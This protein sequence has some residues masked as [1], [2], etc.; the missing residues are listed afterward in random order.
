MNAVIK[1]S[2]NAVEAYWPTLFCKAMEGQDIN[3]LLTN[4]GSAAPAGAVAVSGD[5]AAAGGKIYIS[6]NLMIAQLPRLL[7][8]QRKR[9]KKRKRP[10]LTWVVSLVMTIEQRATT[11]TCHCLISNLPFS[12]SPQY[13]YIK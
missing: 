13:K 10:M 11:A 4:I 7:K 2:G 8:N 3:E 1:A 9:R 5:A 6:L 12:S